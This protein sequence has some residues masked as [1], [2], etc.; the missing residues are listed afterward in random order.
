MLDNRL[1]DCNT[2]VEIE[3]NFNRVLAVSDAVSGNVSNVAADVAE[4]NH[5]RGIE[6]YVSGNSAVASIPTGTDFTVLSLAG[7]TINDSLGGL[8]YDAENGNTTVEN[9]GVYCVS[10]TFSSKLDTTDVIW[11]TAIFVNGVESANLHMRRSFS[12][13]G[14][15][16][17]VCLSGLL[18]LS[19]SDVIDVRVKHNNASAVSI[20]TEYA[21]ITAYKIAEV[22]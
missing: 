19:E 7:A 22:I 12:T 16:F 4:I 14:Y 18:T 21:N 3:A 17:N 15:T 20:T 9:A 2:Q 11:D 13:P 1:L 6:I 10:A 8:T 5:G